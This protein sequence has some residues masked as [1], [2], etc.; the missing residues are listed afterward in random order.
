MEKFLCVFSVLISFF[1]IGMG[2]FMGTVWL[3]G[4][5]PGFALGVVYLLFGN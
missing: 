1:F 5:V 3:W 2:F 4:T